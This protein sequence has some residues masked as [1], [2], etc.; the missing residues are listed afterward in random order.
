M[1]SQAESQMRHMLD[2]FDRKTLVLVALGIAAVLLAAA[3]LFA[4]TRGPGG[5]KAAGSGS[6]TASLGPYRGLGTWVDLY[7]TSAWKDPK[8]AVADMAA[9]GVRTIFVE[10]A[11]SS[12]STGLVHPSALA[13]FIVEAHARHMYV[14]AWYLP[15]LRP[16]PLDF[17]RVT[18][19]I[20][21]TSADGQKF[22][23]FALDIESTVVKSESARNQELAALSA[24]I[25]GRVGAGYALGAIIPSP[26]GLAGAKS[27]WR[28]FPY[29]PLARTYDVFLPMHYYTFDIRTAKAT[30][31]STLAN[32]R[33][34]RAQ[35]GCAATPVHMIGGISGPS[36]TAQVHQFVRAVRET[37]CIGASLY[38]WA[39][40]SA[41]AWK[42]L[43]A[44]TSPGR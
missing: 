1:G 17:D 23:S 32:M 27:H 43:A 31:T 39:G 2:R 8:A 18:Q 26:V 11:N 21:F 25:R 35:P 41:A 10:T 4:L 34:L 7:D 12:S 30:Y 13:T 19:A 20:D 3:G 38:G 44:L 24:R 42:E 37:G 40:T 15:D 14:V 28:G 33:L 29:A 5:T 16:G 22:D 6:A 36:S 9:H